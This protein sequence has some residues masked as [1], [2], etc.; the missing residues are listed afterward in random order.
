[1]VCEYQVPEGI[2]NFSTRKRF[3]TEKGTSQKDRIKH[4]FDEMETRF[5]DLEALVS[6][7]TH[8]DEDLALNMLIR[9]R[10]GES[11][12]DILQ[13]LSPAAL[14][15]LDALDSHSMDDEGY[16]QRADSLPPSHANSLFTGPFEHAAYAQPGIQPPLSF[17]GQVPGVNPT[18]LGMD[19]TTEVNA[20]VFSQSKRAVLERSSLFT[21]LN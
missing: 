17:L 15:V 1:L 12:P 14:D 9:L 20:F 4:K 7:L 16:P 2:W 6:R 11:I 19:D 10:A 13:S 21:Y 3:L 5:G 8:S 18:P